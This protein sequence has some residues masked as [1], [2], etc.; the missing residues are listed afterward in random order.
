MYLL[1]VKEQNLKL[2]KDVK[3]VVDQAVELL[4]ADERVSTNGNPTEQ[5]NSFSVDSEHWITVNVTAELLHH[6][7]RKLE[8]EGSAPFHGKPKERENEK[9]SAEEAMLKH[10]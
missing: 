9:M 10:E 2:L 6:S 3:N 1:S 8:G 4:E 7:T 5:G